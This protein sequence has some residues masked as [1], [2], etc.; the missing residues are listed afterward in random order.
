MRINREETSNKQGI[1]ETK[2]GNEI[3]LRVAIQRILRR[4]VSRTICKR[5]PANRRR[6][7]SQEGN[8]KSGRSHG[9]AGDLV[10]RR[11]PLRLA[12]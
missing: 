12:E 10:S 11:Y 5:W 2:Q 6:A 4:R 9:D 1:S 8:G 3:L 7:L